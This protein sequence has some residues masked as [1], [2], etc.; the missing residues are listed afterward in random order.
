MV[1]K[2]VIGARGGQSILK[3]RSAIAL[4]KHMPVCLAKL[5]LHTSLDSCHCFQEFGGAKPGYMFTLGPQGLGY[6]PDPVAAD[7]STDEGLPNA[8]DDSSNR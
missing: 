3:V 4:R 2:H 1:R 8:S 7:Q 5:H 6:Y